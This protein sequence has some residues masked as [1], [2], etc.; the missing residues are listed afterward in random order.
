MMNWK[1]RIRVCR[2]WVLNDSKVNCNDLEHT[3]G[4]FLRVLKVFF[5]AGIFSLGF[6][7]VAAKADYPY[8]ISL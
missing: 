6:A 7:T 3:I 5:C 8:C 2:S 4:T 1:M